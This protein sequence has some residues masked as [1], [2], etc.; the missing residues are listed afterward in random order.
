MHRSVLRC[1]IT[2]CPICVFLICLSWSS[3]HS[4][5]TPPQSN[6]CANV[7]NP[8][9]F[10]STDLLQ[11]KRIFSF[12]ADALARRG[13]VLKRLAEVLDSVMN[14]LIGPSLMRDQFRTS[15]DS[16]FSLV[17]FTEASFESSGLPFQVGPDASSNPASE[18][19]KKK[20]DDCDTHEGVKHSNDGTFYAT[21]TTALYLNFHRSLLCGY[22][23]VT[24][25]FVFLINVTKFE[26]SYI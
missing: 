11:Y 6:C 23:D 22:A 1:N 25:P 4:L 24:V 9:C 19:S 12:P 8:K 10:S 7:I 13:I 2:F 26:D 20:P 15:Y 5:L 16:G 3:P 21:E 18:N 17:S 14:M